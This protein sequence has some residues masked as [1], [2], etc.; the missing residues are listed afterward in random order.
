MPPQTTT[1]NTVNQTVQTPTVPQVVYD[2]NLANQSINQ[3]Y[4]KYNIQPS[5]QEMVN[6]HLANIQTGISTGLYKDYASAQADVEKAIQSGLQSKGGINQVIQDQQDQLKQAQQTA[7]QGYLDQMQKIQ[8]Q[9]DIAKFDATKD[10]YIQKGQWEQNKSNYL[11]YDETVSLWDQVARAVSN[12]AQ[13]NNYGALTDAQIQSIAGQFGVS[14]EEVK[15]PSLIGQRLQL[16]DQGKM[17][18]GVTQE[19][20]NAQDRQT[21]YERQIQDAQRQL[22]I[23]GRNINNQI[24]DVEKQ[25]QRTLGFMEAAGAWSGANRSTAYTQG[26]QNVRNDANETISRLNQMWQDVQN[27]DIESRARLTQDFNNAVSR[28]KQ[29][30]D[31][32]LDNAKQS[33]MTQMLYL[34][35]KYGLSSTELTT[36]IK[37]INDMLSQNS[38]DAYTKYQ[39]SMLNASKIANENISLYQ[40]MQEAQQKSYNARYEE[41]TAGN[42]AMLK[43]TTYGNIENDIKSGKLSPMQWDQLKNAITTSIQASI[44]SSAGGKPLNEN[45]INSIKQLLRNGATP[46]EAL[47]RFLSSNPEYMPI[48]NVKIQDLGEELVGNKVI[49][50]RGY[51]LADG[52]K[53]YT[54]W[55]GAGGRSISGGTSWSYSGNAPMQWANG[56][57]SDGSVIVDWK[58]YT[59]DMIDTLIALS[60]KEAIGSPTQLRKDLEAAGLTQADL[61]KL[62][63][64]K[65]PPTQDQMDRMQFMYYTAKELL[66]NEDWLKAYTW[67]I[68]IWS[69]LPYENDWINSFNQLKADMTWDNLGKLKWPMSDKD[70]VFIENMSTSMKA[71]ESSAT[72]EKKMKEKLQEII[73]KQES[74]AKRH[75]VL[76]KLQSESV[77]SKSTTGVY[78]QQANKQTQQWS[79]AAQP[80]D[81]S[82][83]VDNTAA[84]FDNL[85]IR[86]FIK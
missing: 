51:M 75:G 53:V 69:I 23:T 71:G 49:T 21:Q 74:I 33:A 17:S 16:S 9:W 15:N 82:S 57:Q 62:K 47:S 63:D 22:E 46:S 48:S 24:A 32:Q 26:M 14:P 12:Q 45:A 54:D 25:A 72:S 60:N 30:M 77:S 56:I 6:T 34:E 11:N 29:Q 61:N 4:Q 10:Y 1:S 35:D 52:T 40:K 19:E 8:S 65:F 18:Y 73:N 39:T 81:Y 55:M 76:D 2:Q 38:L 86:S 64:G 7:G 83:K 68:R 31:F 27:A 44:E 28:A 79:T 78:S 37:G 5:S 84:S 3:A 58:T 80:T 41:Y 66:N 13:A 67:P 50:R 59:K 85:N 20:W 43:S 36:K 42:G 70:L